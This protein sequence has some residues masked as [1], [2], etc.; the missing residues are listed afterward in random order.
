M[1]ALKANIAGYA[2]EAELTVLEARRIG[3]HRRLAR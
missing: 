2:P 3:S 1:P